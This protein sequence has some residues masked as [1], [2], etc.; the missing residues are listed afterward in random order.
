MGRL[1]K[2]LRS[3]AFVLTVTSIATIGSERIFWFWSPDVID[4]TIV[5]S[6]YA[7]VVFL[8]LWTIDRFRLS[9][10]RELALALPLY[11]YLAEGLLTPVMYSGGPFVP[12]FPA[13]F[14]AWHGLLSLGLLV[15]G[16]RWLLLYGRPAVTA[17]AA[18]SIGLFWGVWSA[19]L[20]LPENVNDEDLIADQGGPLHV[21]DPTEF[22]QYAVSFTAILIVGHWLLGHL[23]PTRFE[24]SRATLWPAFGVTA[25]GVTVW[26]VA[27][28]WALPMFVA[29]VGVHLWAMRRRPPVG[30]RP[31]AIH[32]LHGP[33]P[34]V[35][36]VPLVVVAPTAA[37]VYA[38][39]WQIESLAVL[40][41]IMW[42]TIAAQTV[43]GA[44]VIVWALLGARR[45]AG[46]R[47]QPVAVPA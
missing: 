45:P 36:L 46:D 26:T 31:S 29:Y 33:V 5:V 38:L 6:Y 39:T 27:I 8:V 21:L 11:G 4:H 30:R 3:L 28:P 23:W 13:W 12:V 17:V 16:L 43:F 10:W 15:F 24:P 14:G 47:P 32:Q 34:L 41:T 2:T 22:A 42:G 18:L 7:I 37:A 19:T 40:R 44:T 20:R 35:R 9:S 25:L 1:R